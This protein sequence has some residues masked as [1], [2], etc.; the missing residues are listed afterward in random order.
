[1]I[2]RLSVCLVCLA[3]AATPAHAQQLTG[4]EPGESYH[5]IFV[6]SNDYGISSSTNFLLLIVASVGAYGVSRF[7]AMKWTL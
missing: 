3:L 4:V 2:R 5:V 1:M 7:G 6:T